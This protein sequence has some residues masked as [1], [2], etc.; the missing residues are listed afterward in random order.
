MASPDSI[1]ARLSQG[2][3]GRYRVERELGRGG[4]AIVYLALDE[5]H[6]R[7]VAIKVLRPEISSAI[8]ATR[9]L[10]EIQIAAQ[11]NHPHILPLYDSGETDSLLY[12]VMPYVT[13]ESLRE[14]LVREHQMPLH[15]AVQVGAEVASALQYAHLR[16]IVHRDIKP[17][18]ILLSEGYALVADFG[19]ARAITA[20]E[21][22]GPVTTAGI[23][24]GTPLYMSPEQAMAEAVDGRS[25]QY[26]LGCV[27]YEML[28]GRPPFGG[29]TA[30]AIL[31][32]HT[33]DPVPSIRAVRADVPESLEQV[34]SI[35]L[36]KQ[37][38]ERHAA[39]ETLEAALR[40]SITGEVIT[41]RVARAAPPQGRK[42]RR[43][44]LLA[45][46][47]VILAAAVTT[48]ARTPSKPPVRAVTPSVAVMPFAGPAGSGQGDYYVEG[49]S[50]DLIDALRRIPGLKVAP[51]TSSFQAAR[52]TH[53]PR[54]IGGRLGVTYLI[55]GSITRGG[56]RVR[57]LAN[58]VSALNGDTLFRLP[59]DT[60][61][62]RDL[63]MNSQIAGAIARALQV[64]LSATVA[65]SRPPTRDPVALDLYRQGRYAYE[66]R[67][68]ASLKRAIQLFGQAIER[69]SNFA[70]AYSGL[71]DAYSFM[72]A[73]I[74]GPPADYFPRARD[75]AY[76]AVE[77]DS[78]LAEAQTSLGFVA[79]FWD[80]DPR[81]SLKRFNRAIELDSGL[82]R[83]YLFRSHVF[84]TI[85]QP[86]S[87]V[88]SM[89]AARHLEPF[90]QI[91]GTR[92]A[93]ALYFDG[94]YDQAASVAESV[95]AVDPMYS[96]A[97][98]DLVRAYLAQGRCADALRV[99][100]RPA[101]FFYITVRAMAAVAAA[102]CGQP[103]TARRILAELEE[104]QRRGV[105]VAHYDLGEIHAALGELDQAYAAFNQAVNDRDFFM[106][107]LTWEPLFLPLRKDPRF[108]ALTARISLNSKE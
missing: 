43:A 50:E 46:F 5:K 80:W 87:A 91:V 95:V 3:T 42:R 45:A 57:V 72:A 89:R 40:A 10:R 104:D 77:K 61:E 14:R 106:F 64:S 15:D 9:F 84:L 59:F 6:S 23:T 62:R 98:P 24:V 17:E 51:A 67:D 30:Q 90:S 35:S 44:A 78:L 53:D 49:F 18:N 100:D 107:G 92:L 94:K 58:I 29:T 103:A 19:I 81:E 13:G 60:L 31:A 20:A 68:E 32:K 85:N 34:I 27:L 37:P 74:Y 8:G 39:A 38:A 21:D 48:L 96:L 22:S 16:D 101:R 52:L 25:D 1:A 66:Q 70:L 41:R 69:D 33:L 86:D 99:G 12:Y 79:L 7:P 76:Q 47:T 28:T 36:A 11:L 4:M 71:S 88:A 93:T 82:T 75:A 102:K 26:S 55:G 105:Y 56:G 54:V 63:D 83:A 97:F 108:T 73:F 65:P 2:L